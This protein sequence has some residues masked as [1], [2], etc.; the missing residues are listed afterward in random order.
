M[1]RVIVVAAV[2][3][4]MTSA[5]VAQEH[6]RTS[7]NPEV[8]LESCNVQIIGTWSGAITPSPNST[9]STRVRQF[10]GIPYASPPLGAL[11]FAPTVDRECPVA[12][13]SPSLSHGGVKKSITTFNAT[14]FGNVCVQP[15][16]GADGVIGSE[17][18]LTLNIYVPEALA[19]TAA[20]PVL[21][22]IHG[23]SLISGSGIWEDL[24]FL[25]AFAAGNDDIVSA[26]TSAVVVTI[27]YRLGV[28]GFLAASSMCTGGALQ[29]GQCGN[30][31]IQ[32]QVSALRWVQRYISYFGGDRDRVN[33]MGQSSGGTSIFALM[34][35]P[36][37][38]GLFRSGVSLSGSPNI[39]MGLSQKVAQDKSLVVSLGCAEDDQ[40]LACLRALDAH[41]VQAAMPNSWNTPA[42]FT[43]WMLNNAS[44]SGEDYPGLAFVD[45]VTIPAPIWDSFKT[46]LHPNVALLFGNMG[47]E[48]GG[49]NPEHPLF[50]YTQQQW[51]SLLQ[52]TLLSTWPSSMAERVFELYHN[53]S[54]V[55]PQL[56]SDSFNSDYG[57]SCATYSILQDVRPLI[58]HTR[59][60]PLYVYINQWGPQNPYEG[61]TVPFFAYHT[62]DYVNGCH[63]WDS[64]Y[65]VGAEDYELSQLQRRQWFSLWVNGTL[66]E[67]LGWPAAVDSD[68]PPTAAPAFYLFAKK[69]RYPFRSHGATQDPFVNPDVC[70][71]LVETMGMNQR[72]WWCN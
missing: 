35:T 31:G 28:L 46:G 42:L 13:S 33:L 53:A 65:P 21:V 7:S 40:Q 5:A 61:D 8:L 45:G 14:E 52:N 59:T 54:M 3:M 1:N 12:P 15:G 69:S 2:V 43:N 24:R 64:S 19:L 23:G 68:T 22:Y 39:S 49:G 11:R 62:W 60:A 10:K 36:S 67:A 66:S 70:N 34:G 29:A 48:N 37:A 56:A 57:M 25:A 32:D 6:A 27:N 50:H 51:L 38:Q 17:D 44:T 71:Y 4:W 20:A 30:F 47:Q 58:A 72:Y 9:T 55:N 18:C 16:D 63:N 26:Q 41:V